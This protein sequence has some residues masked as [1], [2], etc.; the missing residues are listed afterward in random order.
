MQSSNKSSGNSSS[1]KLPNTINVLLFYSG[2][3]HMFTDTMG[4]FMAPEQ[5]RLEINGALWT[6]RIFERIM[7]LIDCT[8]TKF[9]IIC[10]S[11]G[12]CEI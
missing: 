11:V 6:G 9:A 3:G 1:L 12:G 2:F 10:V 8:N 4:C 5:P 7:S